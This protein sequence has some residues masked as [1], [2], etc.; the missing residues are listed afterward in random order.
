VSQPAQAS[1]PSP[2]LFY[3][4]VTWVLLPNIRHGFDAASCEALLRKVHAAL[5]RGGRVLALEF[6]P[7]ED[8]VSPPAAATFS[9]GLLVNTPA[10]QAYTASELQAMFRAAGFSSTEVAPLAPTLQHADLSRK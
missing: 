1:G 8:R 9:L 7:D 6:V 5:R 4:T 10:G 3:E 2:A